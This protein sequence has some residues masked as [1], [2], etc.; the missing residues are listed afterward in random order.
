MYIPLSGPIR[1]HD[2]PI[3]DAA[4]LDVTHLGSAVSHIYSKEEP[5]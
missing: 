4:L 1:A 3:I 2:R 5:A